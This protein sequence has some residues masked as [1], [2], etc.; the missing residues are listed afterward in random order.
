MIGP[1]PYIGGKR[2]LARRI[3]EIFPEHTTYVE[4]FAGGAQVLF[5]KEPSQ[6]EVINDLDR[7]GVVN[8]FLVC[9]QHYEELLR[10]LRF[11]LVS[12]RWHELYQAQNLDALTD[13]Q[14]AARFFYL[15]K[16]SYAGLVRRHNYNYC[17]TETTKFNPSQLPQLIENV[18]RRLERVQIEC[19]PYEDILERY[20]RPTSLFYCDPPYFG[21]K[22]YR[23]NFTEADFKK[24]AERLGTVQGKFVLSLNDVPEVRAIFREF[25]IRSVE[26]PYTAQKTA[27]RRYHEVLITNFIV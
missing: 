7:D 26:L 21:R 22:L 18:H 16:T 2:S 8:F 9:Q 24:L 10:Y 5:R 17:V 20:D 13:I 23:Y 14:R 11:S 15:Q 3:I 12:R 4:P 27:G 19:A 25:H 1:L 6:V